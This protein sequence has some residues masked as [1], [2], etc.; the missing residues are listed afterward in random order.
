MKNYDDIWEGYKNGDPSL[1]I[2]AKVGD[3]VWYSG[4]AFSGVEFIVVTERKYVEIN[5]FWNKLYF[6]NENAARKKN[7]EVHA[8]Y[9]Y[10]QGKMAGDPRCAW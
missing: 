4:D 7:W 6:D 1:P 5:T 3:K 9:G 8:D 10:W 2:H